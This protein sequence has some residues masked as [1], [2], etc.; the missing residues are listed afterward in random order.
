MSWAFFSREQPQ[1]RK[2][3]S[4]PSVREI[5]SWV[6]FDKNCPNREYSS[7]VLIRIVFVITQVVLLDNPFF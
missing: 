6:R 7:I 3:Q 5:E 2:D 1:H 4:L